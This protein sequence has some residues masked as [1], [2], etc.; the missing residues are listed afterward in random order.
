[1]SDMA[2]AGGQNPITVPVGQIQK[3]IDPRTLL[4]S[5]RTLDRNRLEA[6]RSLLV[7]GMPR[8]T[9]ILVTREGVIWDGHHAVR[10]AAEESR[11]VG[12]Q[13][14]PHFATPTSLLTM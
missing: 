2:S 3:A 4:P 11:L 12:V 13:V 6:Q 9:P 7:A 1:M 14:V 5:R 10:A 8:L